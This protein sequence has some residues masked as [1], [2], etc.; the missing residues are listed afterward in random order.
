MERRTVR[1]ALSYAGVLAAALASIAT[2]SVECPRVTTRPGEAEVDAGSVTTK[3]YHLAASERVGLTVV[4][5]ATAEIASE[6]RAALVPA[7]SLLFMASSD[8]GVSVTRELAIEPGREV[9]ASLVLPPCLN[10]QS[11]DDYH[12]TLT[13]EHISGAPAQVSWELMAETE[14]CDEVHT[15]IEE[16]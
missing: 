11:C 3:R 1:Q 7:E 12:V 10:H 16:L 6:I 14:G 2:S 4:V 13:L 5:H 8:G 9:T 15:V